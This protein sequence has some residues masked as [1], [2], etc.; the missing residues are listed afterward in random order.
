MGIHSRDHKASFID[1]ER[2]K[3]TRVHRGIDVYA[4]KKKSRPVAVTF[5]LPLR[6]SFIS[7]FISSEC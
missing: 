3:L 7:L 6:R 5:R 2:R 4:M 1:T